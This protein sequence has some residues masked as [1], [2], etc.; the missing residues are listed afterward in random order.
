M[1]SM[2]RRDTLRLT[3]AGAAS[4]KRVLGANNRVQV[5]FIG[6]GLIGGQHVHD[7]KNQK[8]ADLAAMCDVYQPR[9][10]QGVAACGQTAKPYSDFRKMLENKDLQAVVV[11]TPDHWHALITMMSCATGK[12]VYVEKPLTLFV[13]EGRWMVNVAKPY[14]RVVQVGT[15]QRS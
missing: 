11:C 7:F 3:A 1:Q 10:E 9:L 6:F 2:T 12:D 4:Y 13:R 15:Q 14:N 5:G 8:D